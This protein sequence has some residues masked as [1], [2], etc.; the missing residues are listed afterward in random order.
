[1]KITKL[2]ALFLVV[3]C[4]SPFMSSI[5]PPLPDS[6]MEAPDRVTRSHD[7][8]RES[9]TTCI[10]FGGA[11]GERPC[12]KAADFPVECLLRHGQPVCWDPNDNDASVVTSDAGSKDSGA[13]VIIAPTDASPFPITC[14]GLAFGDAGNSYTYVVDSTSATLTVS[15]DGTNITT[16]SLDFTSNTFQCP[17][18]VTNPGLPP[19]NWEW[20]INPVTLVLQLQQTWNVLGSDS[21]GGSLQVWTWTEPCK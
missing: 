19:R 15:G 20:S 1:M 10:P 18:S 11:C 2:F 8:G 16:C 12:C 9:A 21:D 4:G 13:D 5:G 7:A 3:G 14:S 17:A 6:G